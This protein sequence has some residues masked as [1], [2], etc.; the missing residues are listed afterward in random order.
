MIQQSQLSRWLSIWIA[1][2]LLLSA[3]ALSLPGCGSGVGATVS[4]LITIDGKPAPAG[5]RID[6]EPQVENAS[7]S[8]GFTDARGEYEM[9]FNVYKVGVLPGESLVR[10]SILPEVDARG[11]LVVAEGL[12]GVRLPDTVGRNSTLRKTVKPGRNR[13]D[14]AIETDAASGK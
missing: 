14:I 4:G 6:F 13:I 10:V 12:E 2:T 7:S 5:I 8:T 11:K 1:F 3:T 9:K